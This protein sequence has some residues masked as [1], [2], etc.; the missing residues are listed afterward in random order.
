MKKLIA[1]V[2]FTV[3]M[4]FMSGCSLQ[5]APFLNTT[6]LTK[7]DFSNAQSLKEGRACAT[8]LFGVIGPLGDPS[9]MKAVSNGN[10]KTVKVV[11]TKSS[12]NILFTQYCVVAY[13]D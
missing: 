11:E 6:D 13:G 7:V 5:T 1:L 8:Y 4:A 9:I 2:I 12:W 10:L 3:C